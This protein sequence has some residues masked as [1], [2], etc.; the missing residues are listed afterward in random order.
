MRAG[1][2]QFD[3][4][5]TDLTRGLDRKAGLKLIEAL[6]I[7]SNNLPIIVYA[8]KPEKREAHALALGAAAVTTTPSSLLMAVLKV[9]TET[10]KAD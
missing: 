3:L 6:R 10:D 4:V 7:Y 8:L 2:G 1:Q 5:I 9:V